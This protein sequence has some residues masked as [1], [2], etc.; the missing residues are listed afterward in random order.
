MKYRLVIVALCAVGARAGY[1]LGWHSA[2]SGPEM[3]HAFTFLHSSHAGDTPSPVATIDPATALTKTIPDALRAMKS[4]DYDEFQEAL[5]KLESLTSIELESMLRQTDPKD[6][7]FRAI[8]ELLIRKDP[9]RTLTLIMD[10]MPGRDGARYME[11]IFDRWGALDPVHAWQALQ[12]LD[13]TGETAPRGHEGVILKHWSKVDLDAALNAWTSLPEDLQSNT[14]SDIARNFAGDPEVREK[15]LAFLKSQP[16]GQGRDWAF[17]NVLQHWVGLADLSQVADWIDTNSHLFSPE[18]LARFDQNVAFSNAQKEP[19]KTA[20]WLMKRTDP[21][22]RSEDLASLVWG[23][24]LYQPN[25]AGAWLKTQVLGPDTDKAVDRFVRTIRDDDPESAYAWS[26]QITDSRMREQSIRN[27]M[28][29]WIRKD[30][31]RAHQAG[32]K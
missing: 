18:Q 29:S 30:P 5:R 7:K 10:L 19:E 25:A 26:Q 2:L 12:S 8:I 21:G 23:W 11:L 9:S 31:K 14:F 13:L 16:D 20:A 17:S 1:H 3:A 4:G 15:L 27:V 6:E 24:S 22:R 28:H 32:G